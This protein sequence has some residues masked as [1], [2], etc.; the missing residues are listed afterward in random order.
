MPIAVRRVNPNLIRQQVES[1]IVFGLSAALYEAITI[2]HGQVQ[3]QYY[4]DFPIVH[5]DDCPVIDTDI[6]SS[7]AEPQGVGEQSHAADRGGRGQCDF[8]ADWARL[9]TLPLQLA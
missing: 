3:Q 5:M 8:C 7:E 4:S 6:M 1:G 9:R 2:D